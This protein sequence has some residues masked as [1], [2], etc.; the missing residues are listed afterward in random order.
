MRR[1][2][3]NAYRQIVPVRW[4]T[5]LLATGLMACAGT[6][7][8][9]TANIDT[10][11][12]P[13]QAVAENTLLQGKTVLWGG[14]IIAAS[15]LKNLTQL[16]ILAYPLDSN[17]K[18]RL[19]AAPLGRFLAQHEGYLETTDYYQGRLL[20]VTGTLQGTSTGKVGESEYN[21]AVIRLVQQH[22][23]SPQGETTEPRVRFG[24]GIMIRN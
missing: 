14:M 6:P 15:N 2:A 4:L 24:I 7:Q 21:Y 3:A 12:T 1:L 16:E 10:A 19:D 17:Q 8:L 9:D 22:L 5:L 20:T 11:I 13:Q 23:W 18:P